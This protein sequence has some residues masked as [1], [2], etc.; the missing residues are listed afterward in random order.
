MS[1]AAWPNSWASAASRPACQRTRTDA[2]PASSTTTA[3]TA[4]TVHSAR[5]LRAR[6]SQRRGAEIG[7]ASIGSPSR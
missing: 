3:A 1:A 7:R 5:C 4:T 2:T 6:R